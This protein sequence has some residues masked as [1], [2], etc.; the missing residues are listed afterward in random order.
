MENLSF[1]LCVQC[2]GEE[3]ASHCVDS[4]VI[5]RVISELRMVS[6]SYPS[7]PNPSSFL[8]KGFSLAT[9]FDATEHLNQRLTQL[10]KLALQIFRS[11]MSRTNTTTTTSCI[12]AFTLSHTQTQS[13]PWI[14]LL[15]T[16][17]NKLRAEISLWLEEMSRKLVWGT[18][19]VEHLLSQVVFTA[20]FYQSTL[21]DFLFN[22]KIMVCSDF[23]EQTIGILLAILQADCAYVEFLVSCQ[24]RFLEILRKRFA[25]IGF[26]TASTLNFEL[27]HLLWAYRQKS[28][29][30]EP[31]SS[32]SDIYLG[33]FSVLD[34]NKRNLQRKF[35]F[36]YH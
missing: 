20:A 29:N 34:I 1:G 18:V 3:I 16:R 19:C 13:N 28:T 36:F 31:G 11:M 23:Q 9:K 30:R 24:F 5:F 32:G 26:S 7:S 17:N 12:S 10:P 4:E 33:D 22:P 2:V 21:T 8:K 25:Y 15:S 35:A 14:E 27:L 6:N